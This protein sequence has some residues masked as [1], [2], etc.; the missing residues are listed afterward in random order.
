MSRSPAAILGATGVVGQRLIQLLASHPWFFVA[1]VGASEQKVGKRY[2][3]ACAW[4]LPTPIPEDVASLTLQSMDPRKMEGISIVFSALPAGAAREVEPAFARAGFT[5]S[6]NASAFREAPDVPLV[7][8]D[9]NPDHL[10]L[11]DRQQQFR[12]WSGALITNP[13]CTVSGIAMVLKP[14]MDAFGL[15]SVLAT[16]MQA[17]SGAGYPGIASIDIVDNVVPWI[18]GEEEKIELETRLLLGEI[19]DRCQSEASFAV[20]AHANRVPVIDGHTVCLSIGLQGAASLADVAKTLAEFRGAADASD[21]PSAPH[22]LLHVI[23]RPDRPQPRLDC[24]V[25]KGMTITV[26]RIRK[27]ALLD[28]RLVLV[29]HNTIRGAAGGSIFNGELLRHKGIV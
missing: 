5:V 17:V 14:L 29:V 6:S 19:D 28:I 26:G 9:V 27:C 1:A 23:D 4:K 8:P 25:G 11:L 20:S 13:N 18:P 21:L 7:I 15:R 22:P 2:H 16:S 24:D 12:G 10:S 3:K